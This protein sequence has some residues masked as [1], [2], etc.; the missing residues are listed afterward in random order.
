MIGVD[1]PAYHADALFDEIDR[2]AMQLEAIIAAA[3]AL[4][5]EAAV[6]AQQQPGFVDGVRDQSVA[7]MARAA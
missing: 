7:S 4:Q 3:I 5:D 2:H 1:Q 6:P